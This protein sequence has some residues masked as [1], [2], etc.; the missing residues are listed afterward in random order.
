MNGWLDGWMDNK[1][2]K[3][4]ENS[5]YDLSDYESTRSSLGQVKELS[6]K[7]N[8]NIGGCCLFVYFLDLSY[9]NH[10]GFLVSMIK[11]NET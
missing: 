2:M 1:P 4:S 5:K 3:H 11:S 8:E 7:N 6:D 10:E 9:P